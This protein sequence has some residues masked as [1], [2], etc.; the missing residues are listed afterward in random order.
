MDASTRFWDRLAERYT[1][2]P[3]ADEASYQKKLE[4]TRSYLGPEA[5]V[6]EFGCGSG[7]TAIWHAPV[8]RHIHAIDSSAK[9]VEIARENAARSNVKNIT[10]EQATIEEI[11]VPDQ[12]L[13]AVLGLSILHLLDDW[14]ATIAKVH[15]TLK[16]GGV[17]VSSTVCLDDSVN[18]IKF[19]APLGKRLGV[20]PLLRSFT[21]GE[22]VASLTGAGFEIDHQWRPGNGKAVFI[23]A[24]KTSPPEDCEP[25]AQSFAASAPRNG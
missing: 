1:R 18:I 14:E 12:S 2:K 20:M 8:V 3:V 24:K 15:R 5:E 4:I 23:V 6:L 17:F 10:I 21:T 19:I 9:M 25:G 22:L 13:D 16:P 7:L 11:D